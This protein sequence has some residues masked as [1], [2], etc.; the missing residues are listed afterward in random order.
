M[1]NKIHILYL[2]IFILVVLVVILICVLVSNNNS[3]PPI[4]KK[5]KYVADPPKICKKTSC[6]REVD[7]WRPLYEG[8][9]NSCGGD[10]AFGM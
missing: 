4:A 7:R 6:N 9:C 8:Y 2:I 1:D 10:M 5:P 3:E